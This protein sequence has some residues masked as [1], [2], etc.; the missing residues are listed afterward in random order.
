MPIGTDN[1]NS[2]NMGSKTPEQGSFPTVCTIGLDR[3]C[4]AADSCSI[5]AVLTGNGNSNRTKMGS[6]A[7][8][9]GSFPTD[10]TVTGLSSLQ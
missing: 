1:D 10:R 8:E 7:S 2:K 6:I 4:S 3:A 9:Q 5:F